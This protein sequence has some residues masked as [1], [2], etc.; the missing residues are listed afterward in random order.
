MTLEQAR[1][2]VWQALAAR[3]IRRSMLGRERC[4]AIVRVALSQ[5]DAVEGEMAAGRFTGADE[6]QR[7]V[8]R[9]VRA[10]YADQC[11]MAFATL[12]LIWAIS[13]IVQVLVLRWLNS[14]GGS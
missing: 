2:D 4:D 13:A 14:R 9:R 1:E 7:R 3:P 5:L 11:G 10:A 6:M 12:L 8:E